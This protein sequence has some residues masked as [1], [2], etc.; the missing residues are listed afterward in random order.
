[1]VKL[2]DYVEPELIDHDYKGPWPL[3]TIPVYYE[4][5]RRCRVAKW[6]RGIIRRIKR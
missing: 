1:M 6:F 3:E 2:A 4:H 5:K